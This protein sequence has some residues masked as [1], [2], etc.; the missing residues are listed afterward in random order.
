ML[1]SARFKDAYIAIII[2][3]RW[4]YTVI[5]TADVGIRRRQ[6]RGFRFAGK[7]YFSART[8][9]NEASSKIVVTA[10]N[11]GLI[12]GGATWLYPRH[13]RG[14]ANRG[15]AVA[16]A[17]TGDSMEDGRAFRLRPENRYSS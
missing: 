7:D 12:N 14:S 17:G 2:G 13:Q 8:Y 9:R 5:E 11:G 4:Q 1:K 6:I 3:S 15:V 10:Q 16:G